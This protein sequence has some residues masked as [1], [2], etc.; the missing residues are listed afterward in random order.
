MKTKFKKILPEIISIFFSLID[1]FPNYSIALL[2]IL[3]EKSKLSNPFC[4]HTGTFLKFLLRN[5]V[6]IEKAVIWNITRPSPMIICGTWFCLEKEKVEKKLKQMNA[7]FL[8]IFSGR[9][10]KPEN[11]Q[12]KGICLNKIDKKPTFRNLALFWVCPGRRLLGICQHLLLSAQCS[13]ESDSQPTAYF[14]LWNFFE[15]WYGKVYFNTWEFYDLFF[16]F[17]GSV[18]IGL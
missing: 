10:R 2:E 14:Q 15:K 11:C 6:T 5:R 16:H 1:Q 17:Q 13:I 3:N 12:K 18:E 7:I 4:L 8:P 9:N